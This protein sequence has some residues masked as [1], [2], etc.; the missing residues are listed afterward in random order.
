MAK[1]A[2]T[3]QS[4]EEL[5]SSL[6]T[7]RQQDEARQLLGLYQKVSQEEAV[8]WYP[9][10]I[11]FG[12]YHYRYETGHEGDS[13]QLSFAPRQ[14]KIT[15]YIDQDLPNRASRLENLGKYKTAVGC[16]Y[17]N[18]LADIHLD[19]LEDILTLSLEHLNKKIETEKE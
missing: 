19:V 10:I 5:I 11:G 9:G 2:P 1:F 12:N 18:K 17:V 8:V 14:A 6:K 16:V 13:P 3:G 7:N 15:L 4:V